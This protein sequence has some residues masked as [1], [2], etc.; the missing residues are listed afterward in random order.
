VDAA[1]STGTLRPFVLVPRAE[2][3]SLARE[4]PGLAEI[5]ATPAVA[6]RPDVFPR[7]VPLVTLTVRE[8]L[9][10]EKLAAGLTLQQTADALVVSYHTIRTQQAS[11]YRKLG[12]DSRPDAVARA[13]QWGLL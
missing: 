6:E 10:I 12:V 1:G 4:V 3:A 13:R 7:T 2:L 9:V 5:L 8:Q 11:I